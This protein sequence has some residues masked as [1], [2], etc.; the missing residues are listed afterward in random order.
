MAR[1]DDLLF[2]V[3]CS[4][5]TH[6]STPALS[7]AHA[8]LFV[9]HMAPLPRAAHILSQRLAQTP[10]HACTLS[11]ALM[12]RSSV[13]PYYCLSS[14]FLQPLS[15]PRICGMH[16]LT[17]T[18]LAVCVFSSTQTC[19]PHVNTKSSLAS[20]HSRASTLFPA[21]HVGGRTCRGHG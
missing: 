4:L 21:T 17:H 7:N 18:T 5:L 8:L 12:P 9:V 16:A 1:S 15:P 3:V 13:A 10:V 2:N 6:T 14:P 20:S 11:C 19:V